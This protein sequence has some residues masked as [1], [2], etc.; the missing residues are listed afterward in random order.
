MDQGKRPAS[1][2]R[3]VRKSRYAHSH[4]LAFPV[5]GSANPLS[6]M[7]SMSRPLSPK[8]DDRSMSSL[9]G[10]RRARDR[11]AEAATNSTGGGDAPPLRKIGTDRPAIDGQ[12]LRKV[13]EGAS[14]MFG[15]VLGPEANEAHRN[16]LHL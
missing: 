8:M 1:G 4:R 14:G 15:T 10:D 9:A 11:H 6:Q 12:F 2:P 5:S 16:H 3:D 13:H 7:R